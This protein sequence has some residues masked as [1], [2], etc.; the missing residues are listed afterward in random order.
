MLVFDLGKVQ[1][2]L[3]GLVQPNDPCIEALALS[4]ALQTARFL[5]GRRGDPRTEVLSWRGWSGSA[6]PVDRRFPRLPKSK[7]PSLALPMVPV[8]P[9]IRTYLN[10]LKSQLLEPIPLGAAPGGRT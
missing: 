1:Y 3:Q 4:G 9:P 7:L 8:L 6:Y 10:A 2:A 5:D